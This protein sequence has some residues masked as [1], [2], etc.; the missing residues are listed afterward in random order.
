M[1]WGG[2]RCLWKGHALPPWRKGKRP[3]ADGRRIGRM[4]E[5]AFN[6]SCRSPDV[7][8]EICD[9]IA[10]RRCSTFRFIQGASRR[11]GPFG[12]EEHSADSGLLAQRF[13]PTKHLSPDSLSVIFR[14][15]ANLMDIQHIP[16]SVKP[17]QLI[18][19]RKSDDLIVLNAR[20]NPVRRIGQKQPRI[21][22]AN[23][24]LA[25]TVLHSQDQP[26]V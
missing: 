15:N 17:V 9:I 26:Q 12:K 1:R 4:G 18:A 20:E 3:S 23:E 25:K 21:L 14:Q 19:I 10:V 6:R 7:I 11:I 22:L 5:P 16:D 13:D 8:K 24:I 2:E